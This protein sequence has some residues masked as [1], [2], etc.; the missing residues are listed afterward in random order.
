[1]VRAPGGAA[2][3]LR[4]EAQRSGMAATVLDIFGESVDGEVGAPQAV[5]GLNSLLYRQGRA[6]AVRE[7][8]SQPVTSLASQVA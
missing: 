1:M 5:P 3:Y 2:L 6:M 7:S 8:T 4:R